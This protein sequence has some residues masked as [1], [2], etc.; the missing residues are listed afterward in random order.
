MLFTIKR[1]SLNVK[2]GYKIDNLL[3]FKT[4]IINKR[5]AKTS[6]IHFTFFF[7]HME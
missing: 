7:L 5:E 2:I 1:L 4:K 6:N 3:K